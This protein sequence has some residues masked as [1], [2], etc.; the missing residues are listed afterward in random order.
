MAH[1]EST[2]LEDRC[3]GCF[4]GLA[5]GDAFGAPYEG[6]PLERL[7]WRLIGRTHSGERRFTDDTQM[8]LDL[9]ETLIERGEV[10]QD[11]LAQRFAKSYRWS[12]GYGPGT[13]KLLKRIRRGRNWQTASRSVYPQGSF[14]NGAAMRAPVV[15][16]FH[17]TTPELVG[18]AARDSA[19][20]THAHPLA[21]HATVLIATATAAILRQSSIDA[22][23]ATTRSCCQHGPLK[24]RLDIADS[25]LQS[26]NAAAPKEVRRHLGNRST[27]LDSTVTAL[28][29]GLRFQRRPWAELMTFVATCGGDADT[30]GAIASALWGAANGRS[31]LPEEALAQLEQRQRLEDIAD[32]LFR[33]SPG[34]KDPE[35]T[36][37]PT[38]SLQPQTS[39]E[40][41]DSKL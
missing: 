8:S 18:E 13:A 17:A 4:L 38:T 11:D 1:A 30:I 26:Q 19:V 20:I 34:S 21:V 33:S 14:G 6:G 25:W 29:V 16:I 15:G 22:V 31:T 2:A 39:E 12:R 23:I 32:R 28:Y 27:A 7:L 24:E 37:E 10:D 3:V 35:P 40:L 5:L 9:A 41:P 36:H